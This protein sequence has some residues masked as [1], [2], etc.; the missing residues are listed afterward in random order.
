MA[1]SLATDEIQKR[2]TPLFA[3]PTIELVVLFGS[4]ARGGARAE[5]DVDLAVRGRN[6]LDLLS[7]TNR[8]VQLLHIDA[9]DVVDLR[10]ASPL[11]MM[12]VMR[13]GRVLYERLPGNYAA[14]CSLAHRRYV[15]TGKLRLA[16]QES[17]QRFLHARGVA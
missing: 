17:I 13:G 6:E 2:L 7:M 3:D 14:F 11:L 12:E 4:R 16:Q 9:V 10:R 5:S 1:S 8:L 15:D